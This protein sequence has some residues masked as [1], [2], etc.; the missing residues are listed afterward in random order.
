MEVV[1]AVAQFPTVIFTSALVVTLVFWLLVLLGRA[2]VRDFDADAPALARALGEAPLTVSASLAAG[3]GWLV[4]LAGTLVMGPLGLTG[5]GAALARIMLLALSLVAAW[6]AAH[7][8]AGPLARALSRSSRSRQRHLANA[9]P[10][11][12]GSRRARD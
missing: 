12:P 1:D 3:S 6:S 11:D 2:G 9:A 8:F 5:L 4:S 7:V 10:F